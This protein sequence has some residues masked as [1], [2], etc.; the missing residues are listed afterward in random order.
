MA[1]RRP[2]FGLL[3][4]GLCAAALPA[5]AQSKHVR[6]TVESLSGDD[7][8]VKSSDGQSVTVKL[9]PDWAA[10]AVVP[11]EL[12]AIKQGTFVGIA[13]SGPEDHLVA[14]EVLVFPPAMKGAGEGHYAWD[15][16]SQSMMTNAT[17]DGEL[18]QSNG[19]ELTL[20]Y[21]GG[22]SK[23]TVP[24]EVP[25]VTFGPGDRSMVKPG[26][27]VFITP[28]ADNGTLTASRVLV[29]KDGLTPPM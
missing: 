27:K 6:G 14:K 7:L 25:V 4:A 18:T 24:P 11:S 21:K 19:R 13:T 23:V 1:S 15:L 26:A 22:Q 9:A 8:M 16:G 12:A 29:G 20:S 5:F 28:K 2:L 17:V 3:L 10:T